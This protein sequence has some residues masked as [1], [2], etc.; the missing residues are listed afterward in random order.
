MKAHVCQLVR[1]ELGLDDPIRILPNQT[2]V[3]RGLSLG[4]P[5]HSLQ[6]VRLKKEAFVPMNLFR[7]G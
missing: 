6:M 5:L 4:L 3:L 7:H 1:R 2:A